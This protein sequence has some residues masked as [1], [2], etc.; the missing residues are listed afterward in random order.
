MAFTL[1]LFSAPFW[2]I[3]Y[4]AVKIDSKGPFI[5]KQK[6]AG[7]DKKS[8][9]MY[10]I[11]TMVVDAERLK[12]NYLKFNEADGPVFKIKNDPR[13]TKVGKVISMLAI[14]E[15]PQLI[16]IIKEEMAFVGPRPLPISE[17]AKIPKKYEQRFSVLPGMTSTWVVRGSHKLKFKTW[18]QLDI[19]YT[20]NKSLWY[21]T[22]ILFLTALLITKSAVLEFKKWMKSI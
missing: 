11:R 7:K 14:D 16:N 18:M 4:L 15:I 9:T 17:A 6:R 19:E 2:L 3:F 21:D 1:L 5:F 10:K 20:K 8:F 22:E 13:Y 12:K